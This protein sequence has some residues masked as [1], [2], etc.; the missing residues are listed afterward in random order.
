MEV[1]KVIKSAT[2]TGINLHEI[3][4]KIKVIILDLKKARRNMQKLV[5][6]KSALAPSVWRLF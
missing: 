2:G 5:S 3:T 4:L 1:T 6:A